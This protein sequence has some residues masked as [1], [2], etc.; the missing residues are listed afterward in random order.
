MQPF[1]QQNKYNEWPINVS[2]VLYGSY[3]M[4]LLKQ[5]EIQCTRD[6]QLLFVNADELDRLESVKIIF[7]ASYGFVN[8]NIQAY[9][10][11]FEMVLYVKIYCYWVKVYYDLLLT[12]YINGIL[13]TV[14][15]SFKLKYLIL[16][17]SQFLIY[18]SVHILHRVP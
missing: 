6:L 11:N 18:K 2:S 17:I 14:S 3:W 5:E 13:T 15:G 8:T 7:C 4:A 10:T 16:L 1:P 9:I 12:Q